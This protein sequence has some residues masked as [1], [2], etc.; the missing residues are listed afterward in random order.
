MFYDKF[1]YEQCHRG[2]VD[3]RLGDRFGFDSCTQGH[4]AQNMDSKCSSHSILLVWLW[5]NIQEYLFIHRLFDP[6]M[7]H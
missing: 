4:S 5:G 2:M 3:H 7:L 6:N 1:Q